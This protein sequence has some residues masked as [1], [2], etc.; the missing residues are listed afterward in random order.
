M[1]TTVGRINYYLWTF[2]HNPSILLFIIKVT[3]FH[4]RVALDGLSNTTGHMIV[5]GLGRMALET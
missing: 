5:R 1:C 4:L 3:L 2:I